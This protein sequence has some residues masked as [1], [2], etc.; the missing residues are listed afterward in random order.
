MDLIDVTA[1]SWEASQDSLVSFTNR[2][3]LNA[4]FTV[5]SCGPTL[6]KIEQS[7]AIMDVPIIVNCTLDQA[8]LASK[9]SLLSDYAAILSNKK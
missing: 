9:A 8:L 5:N 6:L 3:G 1:F 4:F 2:T 7:D